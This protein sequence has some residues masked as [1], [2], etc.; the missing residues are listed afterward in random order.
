[1]ALLKIKDENGKVYEIVAL[2]GPQGLK[3]EDAYAKVKEYGY[4]G[5]EEEFYLAMSRNGEMPDQ[6]LTKPGVA[7]DA[8][9]TGERF[10]YLESL[11]RDLNYTTIAQSDWESI[12]FDFGQRYYYVVLEGWWSRPVDTIV[13]HACTEGMDDDPA[14]Y[15]ARVDEVNKWGFDVGDATI[16]VYAKEKPSMDIPVVWKVV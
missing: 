10:E 3:G 14:A 1:M 9:A 7:A 2:R 12:D 16:I 11:H 8:A 15:F 4:E 13:M 5:S 6:T